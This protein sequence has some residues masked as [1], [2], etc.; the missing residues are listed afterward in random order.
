MLWYGEVEGSTPS[1]PTKP[2][3]YYGA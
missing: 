3:F 2:K 1:V